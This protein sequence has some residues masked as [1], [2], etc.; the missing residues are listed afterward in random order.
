ML[1]VLYHKRAS[2]HYR[3]NSKLVNSDSIFFHNVQLHERKLKHILKKALE[4]WQESR[5][6][7]NSSCLWA[8]VSFLLQREN[9]KIAC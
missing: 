3:I 1:K 9:P 7:R 6:F 4:I 2:N 5:R 8:F